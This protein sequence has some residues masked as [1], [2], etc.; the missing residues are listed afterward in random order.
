MAPLR[1]TPPAH[2]PARKGTLTWV[3]RLCAASC[4][5]QVGDLAPFNDAGRCSAL[6]KLADGNKDIFI[7]QETW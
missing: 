1:D 4:M 5:L 3:A 6:I 2:T 7:A